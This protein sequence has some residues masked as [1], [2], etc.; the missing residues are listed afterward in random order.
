MVSL[1][2]SFLLLC[3]ILR[4]STGFP[5][6]AKDH[7]SC[8]KLFGDLLQNVTALLESPILC[9]GIS[10]DKVAVSQT[11]T[12][13]ACAPN[14]TQ[15]SGCVSQ[16][17][18]SFIESECWRNIN[19]DLAYYDIAIQLYLKSNLRSSQNETALLEPTRTIIQRLRKVTAKMWDSDSY[20]NRNKMCKLMR[21]F[22]LRAI[23][24]NRAI[25]Y[26]SSGDHRN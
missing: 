15:N 4:A 6:S 14:P 23:T 16:R 2:D 24:M 11:E 20:N 1:T 9:F 17:N 13:H 5:V 18:S 10:S 26:M 25:C 3:V 7:E 21:G 12:V 8:V 22:H 19:A